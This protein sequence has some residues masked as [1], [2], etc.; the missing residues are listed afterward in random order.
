[1]AKRFNLSIHIIDFGTDLDVDQAPRR[2]YYRAMV[3]DFARLG[4]ICIAIG[5]LCLTGGCV[6]NRSNHSA[7]RLD[8]RIA[9]IERHEKFKSKEQIRQNRH[10][11]ES[12]QPEDAW[13]VL[14]TGFSLEPVQSPEADR[15]EAWLSRHPEHV[16]HINKRVRLVL[17]Y[18][19]NEVESREMPLELAL[20][21]IIESGVNT[22]ATSI[23]NAAG[24]WQ[25]MP[26]TGVWLGLEIAGAIDERRNIIESTRVSL[27]YFQYLADYYDGNW[28][29][30]ITSYN[31][32]NGRVDKALKKAGKTKAYRQPWKLPLS[33]ESRLY[34]S[35]LIGLKHYIQKTGLEY[36]ALK[37]V[38]MTDFFTVGRTAP[39]RTFRNIAREYN[40][41]L[42]IIS[43]LNA[44]YLS[45][46]TLRN[47]TTILIP[48]NIV[49]GS[50][51]EDFD[52]DTV[53][54][55]LQ[56]HTIR[57]GESLGLI[58]GKYNTSIR[59]LRILNDLGSDLIR[60]GQILLIPIY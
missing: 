3:F 21:P 5:L 22:F 54:I 43:F 32:G 16:E 30:G 2:T 9:D 50:S 12:R 7:H 6:Q 46:S 18:I 37:P 29:L 23:A 51:A 33:N 28:A 44:D 26:E 27:E 34:F 53:D 35:K 59:K 58:A 60:A 39:S 19:I 56:K 20:I 14:R 11:Y 24:L 8:T 38:P 49:E 25:L 31:A 40:T 55:T 45:Q 47:R 42:E 52:L 13:D 41:D 17:P 57:K 4:V 1:M 36:P 10:A 15:Y 48:R